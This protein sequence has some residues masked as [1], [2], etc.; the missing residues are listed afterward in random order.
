M[1]VIEIDLQE[2][3]CESYD[4]LFGEDIF[5]SVQQYAEMHRWKLAEMLE[6]WFDSID[7]PYYF[8]NGIPLFPLP[9]V[10]YGTLNDHNTVSFIAPGSAIATDLGK[11][12]LCTPTEP[13]IQHATILKGWVTSTGLIKILNYQ[14]PNKDELVLEKDLIPLF[15]YTNNHSSFSIKFYIDIF[16]SEIQNSLSVLKRESYKYTRSKLASTNKMMNFTTPHW[17]KNHTHRI[18]LTLLTPMLTNNAT[19]IMQSG[20]LEIQM[21]LL[22]ASTTRPMYL[23]LNETATITLIPSGSTWFYEAGK[24]ERILTDFNIYQEKEKKLGE[25]TLR[26]YGKCIAGVWGNGK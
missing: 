10:L 14:L 2:Q 11:Q 1:A 17:P 3:I 9:R 19:Q 22:S 20:P 12:M 4:H 8:W 25:W 24:N 26:G 7:G 23:H 5:L 13:T 16:E 18:F 21:Q 15:L 6:G